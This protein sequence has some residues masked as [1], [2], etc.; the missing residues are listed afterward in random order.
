MVVIPIINKDWSEITKAWYDMVEEPKYQR[1]LILIIVCVALLLDNML[2]MVIVPII[3]DYLR[4]IG[5]WETHTV[6]GQQLG[7][8]TY[9]NTSSY[10]NRTLEN[11]TTIINATMYPKRR[12]RPFGPVRVVYEG[13][14]SLVGVLFASKAIVQLCVN[15][16]SGALIDKIGYDVPMMIGLTVMFLSTAI[17]ACGQS[18]GVLFFARSLQGVGSA[19][20]D[21]A[22]MAML[23]DRY[24]EEKER[25]KAL[26]IALAFISFGS[27]VGPPFGGLLYEFAGKGVPF[28]ILS[29]VS[30]LDGI[31]VLLV[32]R[33]TKMRHRINEVT[34]NKVKGTP[35]WRLLMDPYIAVT[36]GC[37]VMANVSLAFLEPTIS[38]WMEDNLDVVEWQM[39]I[40]WLPSFL[41]HVLGVYMTV[42]LAERHSK[43][44]WLIAAIG[45][46]LEGLCCFILPFCRTFVSCMIPLCILCFGIALVDT[47]L[48]PTLAYLVDVRHVSIYGS[49]Y[50]IADISYSIAY[51]IGPI[52]AGGIVESIGFF[53]LNIGISIS[54]LMY[55]PLMVV[56]RRVYDYTPFQNEANVLMADPPPHE[57]QTYMMTDCE[58]TKPQQIENA[59]KN[60]LDY[61]FKSSDK[62]NDSK[63]HSKF[64]V[65]FPSSTTTKSE[66]ETKMN[67]NNVTHRFVSSKPRPMRPTDMQR[68]MSSEDDDY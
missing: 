62:Q 31:M 38:L 5:A 3:P 54:N 61:T 56:L 6:G 23:A 13:E 35:I 32:V 22:G 8:V 51:A 28:I 44:L 10:Y 9:L 27:L 60:H 12:A 24:T 50:A 55:A 37:L 49:I 48:L 11:G 20:A 41:P 16:F 18:Y 4:Y 42:K 58:N 2:Y 7:A 67:E 17:F 59:A 57:Y 65:H 52:I 40:I 30:L 14:D 63:D 46:A 64:N 33:P 1:K 39:G 68:I 47:A 66:T 36:A 43:Y 26:G 34:G 25:T 19:F 15:P 53:A 29:L 45:L 21:T